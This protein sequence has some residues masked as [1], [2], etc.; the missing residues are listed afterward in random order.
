MIDPNAYCETIVRHYDKDHYVIGLCYPRAQR[1]DLWP[2]FAF[3]YE[4]AKTRTVVS[5][6]MLGL[7]R[8]QWWRDTIDAL[9]EKQAV[10]THEILPPLW[11][12]IHKY[13]LPLAAFHE[14]IDLREKDME[15]VIANDDAAFWA[16]A[17]A[18][19]GALTRLVLKV[20]GEEAPDY[21][22]EALSSAYMISVLLRGLEAEH[23]LFHKF[24]SLLKEGSVEI[25]TRE[26][27]KRTDMKAPTLYLGRLQSLSRIYLKRL[28]KSHFD[29]FDRHLKSPPTSFL[30]RS[31]LGL[32]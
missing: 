28:E 2:L 1:V 21:A 17:A 16:H 11:D 15:V 20:L 7:I 12:V 10:G 31:L 27:L 24:P 32:S 6:P 4:I 23:M 9:Y 25:F 8:L 14:L 22:I 18:S 13:Q 5:E 19:Q 3:H 26:A 29:V 30:L